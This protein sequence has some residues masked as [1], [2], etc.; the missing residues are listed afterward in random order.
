M[1]P[2]CQNRPTVQSIP[3]PGW[4]V[5]DVSVE[6]RE[7]D[8]E[9][10][11]QQA[12]SLGEKGWSAEKGLSNSSFNR[13]RRAILAEGIPRLGIFVFFPAAR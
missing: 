5:L 8:N 1:F 11:L 7:I 13:G 6:G 9:E 12:L 10:T 2:R 4:S 3:Q